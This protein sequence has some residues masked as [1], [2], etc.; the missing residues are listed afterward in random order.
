MNPLTTTN[1]KPFLAKIFF[2][3]ST[4][5]THE[6]KR[7]QEAPN[8]IQWRNVGNN[9]ENSK[10]SWNDH[11][12]IYSLYSNKR[13]RRKITKTLLKDYIYNLLIF[14]Q[15]SLCNNFRIQKYSKRSYQ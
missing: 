3:Q 13:F 7:E 4:R 12:P 8:N 9:G 10:K 11:Q 14:Y 6:R 15:A 2:L 5:S 1:L